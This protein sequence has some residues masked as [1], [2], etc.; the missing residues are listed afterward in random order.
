LREG[1]FAGPGLL[2]FR[3]IAAFTA[4]WFLRRMP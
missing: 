3:V 2:I 4:D 1:L